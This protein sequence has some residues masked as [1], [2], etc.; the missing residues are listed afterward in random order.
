M[1]V[2]NCEQNTMTGPR[3]SMLITLEAEETMSSWMPSA[4]TTVPVCVKVPRRLKPEPLNG[5]Q[6]LK[7]ERR[8]MQTLLW[9][10]GALMRN[11]V[12]IE[13][14]PTMQ[15]A[16]SAPKVQS[17]NALIPSSEVPLN[18]KAKPHSLELSFPT[19]NSANIQGIWGPWSD[20]SPCPALCGQV[21][22]QLRSRNCQSHSTPCIGPKLEGKE[23]NGP[24]CPKSGELDL[25][26][27]H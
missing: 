24:E 18:I 15:S 3:G 19:D 6:P 14:A 5:S 22:V 8:S 10:S 23:C 17:Y 12:L 4:F 1:F 20:W 9:A 21:G 25:V 2:F 27:S 7:L 26:W 16:S 13:T 11:R